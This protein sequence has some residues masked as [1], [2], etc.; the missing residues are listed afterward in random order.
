M[1]RGVGVKSADSLFLAQMAGRACHFP[2]ISRASSSASFDFTTKSPLA[3]LCVRMPSHSGENAALHHW[4]VLVP[5][6]A[7]KSSMTAR[8]TARESSHFVHFIEKPPI[9]KNLLRVWTVFSSFQTNSAQ[10]VLTHSPCSA[11]HALRQA[12]LSEKRPNTTLPE[13]VIADVFAP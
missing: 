12:A 7:Q 3:A 1:K 4:R 10:K 8:P 5:R 6:A 9:S 11:S 2:P 13:P